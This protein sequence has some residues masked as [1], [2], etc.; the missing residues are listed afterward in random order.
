[1]TLGRGREPAPKRLQ[2]SRD[3]GGLQTL[4]TVRAFGL[5]PASG[6]QGGERVTGAL[7]WGQEG[8]LVRGAQSP[9]IRRLQRCGLW[10]SWALY[11]PGLG[12]R[13]QTELEQP[14]GRAPVIREQAE[15]WGCPPG[16]AGR[17]REGPSPGALGGSLA[18]PTP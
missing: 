12:R 18:L 11:T 13:R 9:S 5:R 14:T 15:P 4:P 17:D 6:L 7:L 16:N 10:G 3:I 1:M 8:P 2:S